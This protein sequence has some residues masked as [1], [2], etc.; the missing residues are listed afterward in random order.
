MAVTDPTGCG[1]AFRAGL[2]YG[3]SCGLDLVDACRV[4][5]LLGSLKVAVSGPQGLELDAADFRARY[6]REFGSAL[7]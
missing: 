5:S 6:Q 3:R 1:D 4:G 7:E 2:L